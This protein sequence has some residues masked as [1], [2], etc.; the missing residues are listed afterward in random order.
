M[1]NTTLHTKTIDK[2]ASQCDRKP[3]TKPVEAAV[4]LETTKYACR[5]T[6]V[7]TVLL[8]RNNTHIFLF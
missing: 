3:L 4:N 2:G 6:V 7:F 8:Q 1:P 5:V